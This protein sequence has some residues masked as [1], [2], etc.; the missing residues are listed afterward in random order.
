MPK[1]DIH[2]VDILAMAEG[3]IHC[4][5]ILEIPIHVSCHMTKSKLKVLFR[6]KIYKEHQNIL[7]SINMIKTDLFIMISSRETAI[8]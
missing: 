5:E 1:A 7:N 6:K 2:C 8:I 3:D 4:V